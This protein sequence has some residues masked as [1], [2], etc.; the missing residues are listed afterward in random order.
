MFYRV[1]SCVFTDPTLSFTGLEVFRKN[2]ASLQ[3]TINRYLG[4]RIVLLHELSPD[5][6]QQSVTASWT[7][8]GELKLPWCPRIEL[9]GQTTYSYDTEKARGNYSI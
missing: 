5:R 4:N 7:M 3:P 8:Y 2:I 1:R 6:S 9:N